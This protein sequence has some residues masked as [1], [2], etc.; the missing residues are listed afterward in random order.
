MLRG[1]TDLSIIYLAI[2]AIGLFRLD[3]WALL[4]GITHVSGDTIRKDC[5]HVLEEA[6]AVA[7]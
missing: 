6:G 1:S 7:P 5:Y 2:K 3:F 4:T